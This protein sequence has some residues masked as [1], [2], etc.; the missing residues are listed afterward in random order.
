[1]ISLVNLGLYLIYI[2]VC[3]AAAV[4]LKKAEKK[5]LL[6]LWTLILM[7]SF[8]HIAFIIAHIHAGHT[9]Y[10]TLQFI[11]ILYGE[12]IPFYLIRSFDLVLANVL[13]FYLLNNFAVSEVI[14]VLQTA[15]PI[16]AICFALLGNPFNI[17]LIIGTIIVT[18]GAFVS[19]FKKFEFPNIFKPLFKIPLK[20]YLFGL[21]RAFTQVL[22]TL[23]L[24]IVSTRT[25][26]TTLLHNILKN[27]HFL[28]LTHITFFST[29]D[30][31]IG[32]A[33]WIITT[34]FLYF[35]IVEKITFTQMKEYIQEEPSLILFNGFIMSFCFFTYAYVF[36]QVTDKFMLSVIGKCQI[37]IT[38]IFATYFIKEKITFPQKIATGL[39]ITGGLLSIL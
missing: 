22:G 9:L 37:P 28:D 36:G 31:A 8:A 7:F 29:L 26:E 20:L 24:F 11:F 19:G 14:L 5:N 17:S 18:I 34:Y 30:Y 15:I 1:M 4:I 13:L 6:V 32:M 2:V 12:N 27:A 16:S 39:I 25:T 38:L 21:L 23:I 33:P 35:F 10:S 3:S